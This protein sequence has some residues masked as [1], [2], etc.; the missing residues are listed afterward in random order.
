MVRARE[1]EGLRRKL[2][3]RVSSR[4]RQT[5]L[6]YFLIV[7]YFLFFRFLGRFFKW[8][9]LAWLGL[10]WLLGLPGVRFF[11]KKK[12]VCAV[13][14]VRLFIF[15]RPILSSAREN[16]RRGETGEGAGA[17]L[18]ISISFFFFFFHGFG[19]PHS[20]LYML[21]CSPLGPILHAG[22]RRE[23]ER[24]TGCVRSKPRK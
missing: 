19:A 5:L 14:C 11:Y 7:Y 24:E 2:I 22:E 18:C 20:W 8:L 6:K 16:P 17:L 4:V 10:A 23:R 9:G 1:R 21:S 12:P 15:I 3:Q 13:L